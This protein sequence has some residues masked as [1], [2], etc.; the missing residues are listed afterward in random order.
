MLVSTITLLAAMALSTQDKAELKVHHVSAQYM[1][2]LI[3]QDGRFKP[4]NQLQNKE[5]RG[6][7]P[8][9][10]EIAVTDG[11]N[12]LTAVGSTKAIL[13]TE[14]I[15]AMFDILPKSISIDVLASVPALGRN[16]SF[17]STVFNNTSL[18][19]YEQS[20][21]TKISVTPRLN[22][23]DTITLGITGGT[24]GHYV[25]LSARIQSGQV[26]YGHIFP[27][28]STDEKTGET[29]TT[30]AFRY[31]TIAI[32]PAKFFSSDDPMSLAG[33]WFF[34]HVDPGL[35]SGAQLKSDPPV[36]AELRFIITA[37]TS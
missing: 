20:S 15:V 32:D 35:E 13:E 22:G 18:D 28:K 33:D 2:D 12:S 29:R 11:K 14:R 8:D 36:E 30:L 27:Q 19:Y 37:R 17:E 34:K 4:D 25:R 21:E 1:Y 9:G 26:I 16:M 24:L 10:V 23:D 6:L 5:W 31:T 3:R 7:L